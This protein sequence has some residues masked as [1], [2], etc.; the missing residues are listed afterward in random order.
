LFCG[1]DSNPSRPS[2]VTHS[3]FANRDCPPDAPP[4]LSV[5]CRCFAFW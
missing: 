5:E 3:A 4:R 2:M 1:F